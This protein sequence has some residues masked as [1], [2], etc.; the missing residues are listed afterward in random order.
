VSIDVGASP[1]HWA[2]PARRPLAHLVH[3]E[4]ATE[5]RAGGE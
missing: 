2:Q 4:G 3:V 5:L 1:V